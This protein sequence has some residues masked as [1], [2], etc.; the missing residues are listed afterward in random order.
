LPE[1]LGYLGGFLTTVCYIPQVIRIFKLKSAKEISLLFTI[2]LLVGVA[3]W[4]VYGIVLSL[5]PIV[6][7]NGI[8]LVIVLLLLYAKLKYNRE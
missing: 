8:G 4:F 3:S 5:V 7:W 1:Y 6:L 2:L